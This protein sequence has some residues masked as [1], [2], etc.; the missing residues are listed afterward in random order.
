[1][2]F[3][4]AFHESSYFINC[5][6]NYKWNACRIKFYSSFMKEYHRI[7]VREQEHDTIV[8]GFDAYIRGYYDN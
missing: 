5:W 7:V 8:V 1:M 4:H 2:E 3:I 6:I